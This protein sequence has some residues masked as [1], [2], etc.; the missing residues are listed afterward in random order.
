M[1][2]NGYQLSCPGRIRGRL[3]GPQ[4]GAV[5]KP[6]FVRAARAVTSASPGQWLWSMIGKAMTSG[7]AVWPWREAVMCSDNT[8]NSSSATNIAVTAARA[9]TDSGPETASPSAWRNISSCLT[10]ASLVWFD[11]RAISAAWS[12]H[13]SHH[14]HQPGAASSPPPAGE[15]LQPCATAV[16]FLTW[17][18]NVTMTETRLRTYGEI[19]MNNLKVLQGMKQLNHKIPKPGNGNL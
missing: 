12:S 9:V 17:V 8:P 10:K 11:L 15:L 14:E 3:H 19:K 2:N 6:H 5:E 13:L 7:K 16:V 1:L 18:G 4:D